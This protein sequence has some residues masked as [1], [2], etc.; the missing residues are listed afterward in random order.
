MVKLHKVV[1][2]AG[3]K[4]SLR[5]AHDYI[6]VDSVQS[7]NTFKDELTRRVRLLKKFPLSYPREPFLAEK[8]REYRFTLACGA[9]KLSF[10]SQTM[11]SVL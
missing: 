1:W 9:T 10:A 8:D 2:S 4:G 11:L 5:K 7:A 6:K 3:A